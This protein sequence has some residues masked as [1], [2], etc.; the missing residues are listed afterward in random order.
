MKTKSFLELSFVFLVIMGLASCTK[1]LPI[2]EETEAIAEESTPTSEVLVEIYLFATQTALASGV[3]GETPLVATTP[4]SI[5]VTPTSPVTFPTSPPMPTPTATVIVAPSPTP[6]LPATYTLQKGEFPYCIARRFNVDPAE[7]LRINGMTSGSIYYAGMTLKIP[8]S[9]RPFP[10]NRSLRPHP[11]TY[12]V[13][14][15][16]TIYSIACLFGDV[17]PEAIAY[18][19]GLT[20]PYRLTPGMVLNIP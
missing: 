7:L 2:P 9:G 13:Q 3:T 8:Q 12:T 11:T 10:G 4:V 17:S 6:G 20:P 16:D 5:E 14:A 19:N 18:V 15:G 1:S